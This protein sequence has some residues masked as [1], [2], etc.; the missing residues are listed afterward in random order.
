MAGLGGEVS[1]EQ[2]YKTVLLNTVKQ[3]LAKGIN[4]GVICV[5]GS[6]SGKSTVLGTASSAAPGLV[7]CTAD[8]VFACV[9]EAACFVGVTYVNVFNEKLSDLLNPADR[10]LKVL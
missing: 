6:K 4:L 2:L 1:S 9:A 7:S 10:P 3:G 8:T 5:G